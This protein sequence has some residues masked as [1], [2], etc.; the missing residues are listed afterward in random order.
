MEINTIVGL[1]GTLGF[2]IVACIL[3]GWFIFQIY[4]KTT[5]QNEDNMAAVQA[6]CKE[7]EDKLYKFLDETKE[8]NAQALA[9]IALYAERLGTIE[10]DVREIKTDIVHIA[11]RI[12]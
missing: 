11:E 3:M 12:E 5:K 6:R 10:Q 8:V 9:T 2:P 7:R 1:I 4:K